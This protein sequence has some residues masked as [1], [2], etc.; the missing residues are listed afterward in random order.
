MYNFYAK[1][2]FILFD[3][4]SVFIKINLTD[5]NIR[6]CLFIWANLQIQLGGG[7][8]NYFPN[9]ITENKPVK[10]HS[11]YECVFIPSP[12]PKS[13]KKTFSLRIISNAK[14]LQRHEYCR[15]LRV[16]RNTDWSYNTK[17]KH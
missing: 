8:Q 13:L 5:R 11:C 4:L 17:R 1:C 14:P 7:D 15:N 3:I 10:N 2:F 6:E 9:W 16:K 12:H